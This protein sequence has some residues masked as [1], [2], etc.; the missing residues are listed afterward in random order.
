M[1]ATQQATP[2]ESRRV[3][4]SAPTTVGDE[5]L[6]TDS[7]TG[8]G[9][10]LVGATGNRGQGNLVIRAIINDATVPFD[11]ILKRDGKEVRRWPSSLLSAILPGPVWPGFPLPIRPGQIQFY[12]EQKSGTAEP[13]TVDF[14]WATSLIQ[15]VS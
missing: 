3:D 4:F 9:F 7:Q 5:V 14:I 1:S 13:I 8:Q 11:V 15:V 12:A 10:I 2:Q 6:G